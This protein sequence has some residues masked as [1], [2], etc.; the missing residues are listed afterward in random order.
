[1]DST[2]TDKQENLF[3]T[4]QIVDSFLSSNVTLVAQIPA[5]ERA[6]LKLGGLIKTIREK[7]S[8]R[9][10]IK[11]GKTEIKWN[12]RNELV[13]AL[14][15]LASGLYTY[16]DEH[17]KP[18]ILHRVDQPE[19]YYK[20][21]RDNILL[22]EAQGLLE[23]TKGIETELADHGITAEELA[24][25]TTAA[26]DYEAA[27]KDAGTSEAE[28]SSATKTV[29]QLLGEAK[30]L[31]ENQLDRHVEKFRTKNAEFYDKYWS[32]RRVIDNGTRHEKKPEAPT[33]PV[34]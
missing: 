33:T 19:S 10:S 9:Q 31:I 23:L 2:L 7:D 30:E 6:H 11:A 21:M 3:S 18:E 15:Q 12:K 14:F 4:C 13:T 20:R 27:I 1:M 29:Y 28:G 17:K 22:M 25:C 5:F 32:A 26:N 34:S 8:G 16:A 24:S